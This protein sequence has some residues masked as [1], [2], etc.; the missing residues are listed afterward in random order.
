MKLN[1]TLDKCPPCPPC[2]LVCKYSNPDPTLRDLSYG[3]LLLCHAGGPD[4]LLVIDI[5]NIVSVV[6]MIP[7]RPEIP[8]Q[9]IQDRFFLVEK[10]GLS[11]DVLGGYSENNHAT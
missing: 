8:N 1:E 6:A 11:M 3:T 7:H 2:A 5:H 4:D 9:P 10:P